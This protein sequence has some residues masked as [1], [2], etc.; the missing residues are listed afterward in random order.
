MTP[1]KVGFL[2]PNK[3]FSGQKKFLGP[4]KIKKINFL[5]KLLV[6]IL[7]TIDFE[8]NPTREPKIH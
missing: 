1:P 8:N 7:E 6:N 2:M 5:K 3:I 4:P